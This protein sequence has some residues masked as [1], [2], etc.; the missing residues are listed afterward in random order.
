M[1][2]RA[3]NGFSLFGGCWTR[4]GKFTATSRNCIA[5]CRQTLPKPYKPKS[6][7]SLPSGSSLFFPALSRGGRPFEG[8]FPNVRPEKAVRRSGVCNF[9][10]CTH[11]ISFWWF[12]KLRILAFLQLRPRYKPAPR[13]LPLSPLNL[14]QELKEIREPMEVIDSAYCVQA[15]KLQTSCQL[16]LYVPRS[17]MENRRPQQKHVWNLSSPLKT[18]FLASCIPEDDL[19]ASFPWSEATRHNQLLF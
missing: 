18:C 17:L 6:R 2:G 13:S 11:T 14:P 5:P 7:A 4:A 19:I 16:E 12:R 15:A 1:I 8:E 3:S 10:V 9:Y